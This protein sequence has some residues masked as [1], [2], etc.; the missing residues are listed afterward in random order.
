MLRWM[1]FTSKWGQG[2]LG[3]VFLLSPGFRAK[4]SREPFKDFLL[5]GAAGGRYVFNFSVVY[6][7]DKT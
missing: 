2:F 7:S 5:G 4:K 1:I 3:M 6:Q